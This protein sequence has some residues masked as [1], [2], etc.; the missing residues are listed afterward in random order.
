MMLLTDLLGKT[1][2][3]NLPSFTSSYVFFPSSLR[4]VRSSC[5]R[6]FVELFESLLLIFIHLGGILRFF[7]LGLCPSFLHCLFLRRFFL[8]RY[9]LLA[10]HEFLII[11]NLFL[12]RKLGRKFGNQGQI[13]TVDVH[14]FLR[15]LHRALAR[16]KDREL[17]EY[18]SRRVLELALELRPVCEVLLS[19]R[20][21]RHLGRTN[22]RDYRNGRVLRYP[23]ALPV[24]L[25]VDYLE[26]DV[27]C[28]VIEQR[29]SVCEA[30]QP[31]SL[32][33]Q[34]SA[35]RDSHLDNEREARICGG[36]A[37]GRC[38]KLGLELLHNARSHDFFAERGK[39]RSVGG[40]ELF[41]LMQG[42]HELYHVL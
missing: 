24:N 20:L 13:L 4:S 21:V 25:V 17:S 32:R 26:R 42:V 11:R 22:M 27:V 29:N 37:Y 18:V 36:R 6:A 34:L 8:E 5:L 33:E 7:N 31:H 23:V 16:E 3:G 15:K 35:V 2:C 39:T 9:N 10:L 41:K 40:E 14:P 1:N 12:S 19:H 30:K 38:D 28:L